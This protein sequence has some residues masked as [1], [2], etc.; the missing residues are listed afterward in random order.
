[1][2][3]NVVSL[4]VTALAACVPGGE[5]SGPV[6]GG[7]GDGGGVGPGG[8][9]ALEDTAAVDTADTADDT[10]AHDTAGDTDPGPGDGWGACLDGLQAPFPFATKA[11]VFDARE[12]LLPDIDGIASAIGVA[13][14]RKDGGCPT[15]TDLETEVSMGFAIAG[16]C[17]TSEGT[18]YAGRMTTTVTTGGRSSTVTEWRFEGFEVEVTDPA[19]PYRFWADGA[20][21]IDHRNPD[22]MNGDPGG[23]LVDATLT[24]GLDRLPTGSS[25]VGRIGEW[26]WRLHL[27]RVGAS[28][29]RVDDGYVHVLRT[30]EGGTTGDYCADVDL[31]DAADACPTEGIGAVRLMGANAATLTLDGTQG[32]DGCGLV[33][34]DGVELGL[35]CPAAP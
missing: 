25:Y 3:R 7:V 9:T 22:V 2:A 4:L 12:A 14:F 16:D 6:G 15:V 19:D 32:C 23:M 31:E 26:T 1:M 29:E 20:L 27:E 28:G 13:E 30:G 21:I 8:D 18:R 17:T 33:N 24:Q 34:V 5:R 11:D 35:A 10:G